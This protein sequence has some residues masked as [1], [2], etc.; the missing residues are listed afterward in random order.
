MITHKEETPEE[1]RQA[2]KLPPAEKTYPSWAA[3]AVLAGLLAFGGIF[4]ALY[5]AG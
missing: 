2:Q 4:Y 5:A 3:A 1:I